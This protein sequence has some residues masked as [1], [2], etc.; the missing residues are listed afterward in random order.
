MILQTSSTLCL[1]MGEVDCSEKDLDY[2]NEQRKWLE[3]VYLCRP[4]VEMILQLQGEDDTLYGS[5]SFASVKKA[6]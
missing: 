6:Q 5:H 2:R 4:V 1:L 3:R